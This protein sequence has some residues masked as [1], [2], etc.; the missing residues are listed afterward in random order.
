MVSRAPPGAKAHHRD[1]NWLRSKA[2]CLERHGPFGME[3]LTTV[4]QNPL[5][6]DPSLRGNSLPCWKA[7]NVKAFIPKGFLFGFVPFLEEQP[8][9]SLCCLESSMFKQTLICPANNDALPP[10]VCQV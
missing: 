8:R 6:G 5:G 2:A 1:K 7:A 3:N 4:G 9:K 10:L